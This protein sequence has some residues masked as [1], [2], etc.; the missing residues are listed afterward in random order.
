[1]P[2]D[3]HLAT[4]GQRLRHLRRTRRLTLAELGARVGRAPSQLSLIEN[5]R[6]EPKLSLISALADALDVPLDDLL[7]PAPPSRRAELEI[8]LEDSQQEPLYRGLELPYL[9]VGP[10]VPIEVLEH[11]AALYTELRRRDTKPTATP[12]E[13]RVANAELRRQMRQRGN[14]FPEI[15]QLA[16]G[17]LDAVGYRSGTL[18][19]ALVAA[20]V[21]HCGFSVRY[22]EDLPRSVRSIADL[23]HRC[24]YLRRESLGM[25]TPR[26]ILLQT[27]GHFVLDHEQPRDFADFL[28]QRVE[29]NYFA[30]AVLV[31]EQVAVPFLRRARDDRDLAV[32]DLRDVFSVSYEMAAHR[33][34]NLAT[35]HLGVRCHFVRNDEAGTIYKAYENDG[36]VFP[37]DSSGAIE[38]QRMCRHWAG[39]RVFSSPDRYSAYYQYTDTPEGTHWCVAHVDPGR[40]RN[41]AVTLG[42]PY[43]DSRWFRGRET[44]NRATSRCPAGP[45]CQRP[46]APLADRWSGMAWP[47]AR[48]HSHVLA[49]L[50]PGS[51]PGVDETDVYA[52][53][54]QHAPP[55]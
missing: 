36:L 13:A 43:D 4:F 53:L 20:I 46:P 41:F 8:A 51:F 26:G 33:F 42:V 1:M 44:T 9:R 39:R 29:A 11:L 12:E 48:A 49:V 23:R 55:D 7:S 24:I 47:S 31:P 16:V 35:K 54:D 19:D 6:R 21:L 52:F 5:G 25:H 14:Y 45:C 32:E 50:P 37:S 10:R 28:R 27:L 38:G 40:E 17:M 30:A 3:L 18:S 34:T 22:A 2:T 15:E